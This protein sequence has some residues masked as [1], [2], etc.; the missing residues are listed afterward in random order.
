MKLCGSER[1][2]EFTQAW[3]EKLRS[4]GLKSSTLAV[5]CNGVISISQ[6]A[7]TIVEDPSLCPV[8]HLVNLRRQ[9]ESLAKVERL[10]QNKS[11][12]WID[13]LE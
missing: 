3:M 6:Y 7:L 11:E 8:E 5:Y 10:Y 9:A 4:L 1:V 12:N 2:A 13:W